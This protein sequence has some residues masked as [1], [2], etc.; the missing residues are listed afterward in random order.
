MT[1]DDTDGALLPRLRVI[2]EQPLEARATAYAQVHDELKLRLEGG[3]SAG[4][5]A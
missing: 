4:A 5:D 1:P 2:E 3:D